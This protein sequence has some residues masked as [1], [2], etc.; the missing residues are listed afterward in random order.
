LPREHGN[1]T[2]EIRRIFDL[3]IIAKKGG[4]VL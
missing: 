2:N 3:M 4:H 1:E